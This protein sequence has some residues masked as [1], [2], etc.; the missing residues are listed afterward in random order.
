[1]KEVYNKEEL[2][3]MLETIYNELEELD[4]ALI[5]MHL[6]KNMEVEEH[7]YHLNTLEAAFSVFEKKWVKEV[8]NLDKNPAKLKR[9]A[10]LKLELS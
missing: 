4:N 3:A 10:T 5:G 8:T 7:L 9:T 1:M 6:N 2:L